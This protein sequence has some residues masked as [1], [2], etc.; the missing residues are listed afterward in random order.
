MVYVVERYL[1]GLTRSNLLGTLADLERA[2][3]ELRHGPTVRYLGSTIVIGDEACFCQFE[4]VSEGAVA[5]ANRRAGLSFDRIVPAV[6]VSPTQQFNQG[7]SQM[8]ASTTVPV[9]IR[10]RRRWPF[11][12]VAALLAAGCTVA[13]L[14]ISTG[15]NTTEN[16][17]PSGAASSRVKGPSAT[18]SAQEQRYVEAISSMTPAQLAAAFGTGGFATTGPSAAERQYV[19]AIS[20]MTPAQIAAAFGT[21]DVG[22]TVSSAKERQYVKAISSMTPAQISAAFGS[23]AVAPKLSPKEKRYVEGIS[24]L[25]PEQVA[26]AFG[27]GR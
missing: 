2:T 9:R 25:S 16:A 27:N 5:E 13:V 18:S 19:K 6:T 12:A 10:L 21:G 4:A 23:G 7:R 17:T 20:S 11:V 22:A 26:A 1:P 8:N 3:E 24:S 14:A 15:S